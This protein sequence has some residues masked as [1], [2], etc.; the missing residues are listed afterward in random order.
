M[1]AAQRVAAAADMFEQLPVG[2]AV[3]RGLQQPVFQ[4]F[5]YAVAMLQL[6]WSALEQ[7]MQQWAQQVLCL[8][9]GAYGS[10][11]CVGGSGHGLGEQFLVGSGL[12]QLP[13]DSA[14][15]GN[16]MAD[17]LLVMSGLFPLD[18]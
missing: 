5:G 8:W 6:L 3:A 2:L 14:G 9:Q 13:A 18:G 10:Q 7:G 4:P 16:R 12:P 15:T 1:D 17:A 11:L